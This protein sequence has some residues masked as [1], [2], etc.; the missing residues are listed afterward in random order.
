MA[1]NQDTPIKIS[2]KNPVCRLCCEPKER[3]YV[4][5]I[6]HKAGLTQELM[7]K[8]K[9]SC[10]ICISENDTKSKVLCRSC[11]SFVNKMCDFIRKVRRLQNNYDETSDEAPFCKALCRGIAFLQSAGSKTP[12][13]SWDMQAATVVRRTTTMSSKHFTE[14]KS[15][16][17]A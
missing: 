13:V 9:L 12:R 7:Q 5:Q 14:S 6:F 2:A 16:R 17:R 15:M 4:I 10:G 8:V 11:V 3:R 1:E